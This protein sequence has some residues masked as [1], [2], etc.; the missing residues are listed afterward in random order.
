MLV[1]A[2]AIGLVASGA[3]LILGITALVIWAGLNTAPHLFRR[4]AH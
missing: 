1:G 4:L 3:S 2:S